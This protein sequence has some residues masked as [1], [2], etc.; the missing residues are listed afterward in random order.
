[1]SSEV[2]AD[3]FARLMEVLE[4]TIVAKL[5]DDYAIR[6]MDYVGPG[7]MIIRLSPYCTTSVAS[8]YLKFG[9]R[10]MRGSIGLP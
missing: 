1:V 6:V 9:L 2:N 8:R 10:L 4:N 7:S 3:E 5:N